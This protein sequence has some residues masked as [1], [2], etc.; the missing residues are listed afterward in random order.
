MNYKIRFNSN[1]LKGD[2]VLPFSKSIS[3]RLLVIHAFANHAFRIF[4]LSESDDTRHMSHAFESGDD[5]V[6]I[7]HA[8]TAMR[9]LTAYFAAAGIEKTITGSDRMKNRPIGELVNA[10]NSLGA[11]ITYT[12]KQG[13]PPLKTSG[14]ILKGDSISLKGSISSQY[15]TALLLIAPVLPNGLTINITDHLISSSYVKL[16]LQMM[17]FFGIESTWEGNRI[18]IAHQDYK[19]KDYTV[20]ADWSGASYWYQ[21]AMLAE[22]VE[23]TLHGL[24][25]DSAQGDAAIAELFNRTGVET[26]YENNK[27]IISKSADIC[28]FFEADFINTPDMV[29]TFVVALC[30]RGIPFRISGAQTLRIKETDRVFALQKEMAKFGFT[31]REPEPGVLTWDGKKG[32]ALEYIAIETYDDHRMAL[33]FAPAAL[34][35]P[36][37]VINNA[38]VVTKSYPQYWEQLKAFGAVLGED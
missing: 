11:E 22:S 33:A 3:N 2:V 8:G 21:L 28:N 34:H 7:G 19:P 35:Y 17:K 25:S 10:L 27:V 18:T 5:V 9:F 16:T 23:I 12:E 6:N 38:E 36:G 32:A 1:N 14:K 15:I 20:E 26:R 29:Q 37:M 30:L 24:F 13:F 31:I 4:N